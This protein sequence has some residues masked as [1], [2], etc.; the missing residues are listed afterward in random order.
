MNTETCTISIILNAE[1]KCKHDNEFAQTIQCLVPYGGY[2]FIFAHTS[3]PGV[4]LLKVKARFLDILH[5]SSGVSHE[6]T[7]GS[8]CMWQYHRLDRSTLELGASLRHFWQDLKSHW[9][10][11]IF[12]FPFSSSLL[13][14]HSNSSTT[15][16]GFEGLESCCFAIFGPVLKRGVGG[17]RPAVLARGRK[18]DDKRYVFFIKVAVNLSNLFFWLLW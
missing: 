3:W 11:R 12:Q 10:H 15:I 2:P 14:S 9:T 1:V 6:R 17:G 4:S 18:E 7:L 8:G 13:L 5:F 16:C